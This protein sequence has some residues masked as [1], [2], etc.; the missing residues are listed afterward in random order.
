[1]EFFKNELNNFEEASA[2]EWIITNGI[3]GYASSTIIGLNTRRYHGLLISALD[4]PGKRNL[5]LSK[6]DESIFIGNKKYNLYTNQTT[7]SIIDGYKYQNYFKKTYVPEFRY[8]IEDVVIE[9]KIVFEYSKNTIAIKYIIKNG[10]QPSRILLA[11]IVNYR[12]F[13]SIV[14]KENLSFHQSQENDILSININNNKP[15]KIWVSKSRYVKHNNDYFIDMF[16]NKEKER[17]FDFS[18][19]HI[20]PGVFQVDIK[21][22]MVEQIT[23][24]CSTENEIKKIDAELLIRNEE[25]RLE[26]IIKNAGYKSELKNTLIISSDNF[27][28]KRKSNNLHTIIAGY[29]WFLDWGRDSLIAFEGI[30]LIPKRYDI[31]KE[32]ILTYINSIKNGLIPNGFSEYDGKPLYNSA[33]ASL[34]LFDAIYKY[35]KYTADYDFIFENIYPVLKEIIKS[36]KNGTDN[37]IYLDEDGLISAGNAF[38]QLTWMDAQVNGK[39]VTP[40]NGK[41]VELNAMW[42]N[43]LNILAKF[44]DI[45]GEDKKEYIYLANKC[46]SNFGKK[47]Y[48]KEKRYLNDL[49]DD[50][51]I[52]PNAL[53]AT[54]MTF[55]II[56]GE[57][58]KEIFYTARSK[59]LTKYGLKTLAKDEIGYI[60][61]YEGNSYSRDSAYHQGTV[62]PWLLG[63]YYDTL[64]NIC[65]N[66]S[67]KM[68]KEKIEI[69]LRKFIKQIKYILKQ[70]L[71]KSCINSISEIYDAESPMKAKGC[72]AQAWSVS[73]VLRIISSPVLRN[74][75]FS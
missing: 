6:V 54:G 20:V 75:N 16:Y 65:K 66:E 37:S 39:P 13:H 35:A 29:P 61:K 44:C 14:K 71:E 12:D 72:F 40:R 21:P 42:Y 59:L 57:K 49:I 10:K 52:R 73:E 69:E 32:V 8:K 70:E 17:G 45:K 68:E 11:P 31:A 26:K 1:M 55:P 15:I 4:A 74:K 33:D 64:K 18:E 38:S 5:I 34:L 43:A 7:N 62:W 50:D 46:K 36:Y 53:F 9:K 25:K 58:S 63:I 2:K 3:G 51:K 30:L 28:V 22:Y 48:N 60:P 27:I 19:D 56:T 23:F 47:F 41:T 67:D 24:I